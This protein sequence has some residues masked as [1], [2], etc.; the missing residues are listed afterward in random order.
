MSQRDPDPSVGSGAWSGKVKH[1]QQ[2]GR[3]LRSYGASDVHLPS[4][5][6]TDSD[7]GGGFDTRVREESLELRMQLMEDEPRRN[8]ERNY[9]YTQAMESV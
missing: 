9:E 8:K 7:T 4:D 3:P 1:D 5:T 2:E 6:S